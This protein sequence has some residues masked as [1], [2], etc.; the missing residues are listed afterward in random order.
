MITE[1]KYILITMKDGRKKLLIVEAIL[2]HGQLYFPLMDRYFADVDDM[3][4]VEIID[5]VLDMTVPL[6]LQG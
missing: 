6:G 5:T 3:K 2:E 1:N 4:S